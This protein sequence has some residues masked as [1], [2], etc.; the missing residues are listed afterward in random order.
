MDIYYESIDNNDCINFDDFNFF[1]SFC[2]FTNNDIKNYSDELSFNNITN[3]KLY[4]LPYD[5]KSSS[6][7]S[8]EEK[9][10]NIFDNIFSIEKINYNN[11]DK[12]NIDPTHN[13]Y[14]FDKIKKEIFPKYKYKIFKIFNG[15]LLM[16]KHLLSLEKI[17]FLKKK[18][19]KKKGKIK[20]IE[21]DD[22]ESTKVGRKK[23]DDFTKRKHNI[24]SA[25]NII[26]KIK[27]KFF[28]YMRI[29]LNKV[30]NSY[31]VKFKKDD[32]IKSLNFQYI[33]IMKKELELSLLNKTLKEIFSNEISRKYKALPR[34]YNKQIIDTILYEEKDNINI[35]FAFN[36]TFREWIDIFTYKKDI[37][38]IK[39][40][41]P[42]KMKELPKLIDYVDKLLLDMYNKYYYNRNYLIYFIFYIYNYERWFAVKIGRKSAS[43]KKNL[44]V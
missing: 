29:F 38:S 20:Y 8:K 3:Y 25:D 5:K 24:F 19:R 9:N 21:D 30:L 22:D 17:M 37:Q 39:N 26:R 16:D 44:S 31:Y 15:N 10:Q 6:L 28:E 33:N 27:I 36:L 1:E 4:T 34:D 43:E 12:N 13:Q 2:K 41:D 32:I 35:I 7:K 14:T 23:K 18:R 42:E 11:E 40:F